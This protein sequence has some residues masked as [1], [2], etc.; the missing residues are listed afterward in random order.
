[1]EIK[2]SENSNKPIYR[3]IMDAIVAAIDKNEL[4]YGSKLPTE[5]EMAA[6]LGVSRGTVKK[7]FAELE[8]N[9]I[10]SLVWGSGAYVVY[11]T[12]QDYS[13]LDKQVGSLLTQ[14]EEKDYSSAEAENYL[15]IKRRRVYGQGKVFFAVV[16]ETPE[17]LESYSRQLAGI[18][19]LETETFL[20]EELKKYDNRSAI[21]REFDGILTVDACFEQMMGLSPELRDKIIKVNTSPDKET[22]INLI[23]IVEPQ[24]LGIL[25]KSREFRDVVN[26]V[27]SLRGIRIVDKDTLFERWAGIEEFDKFIADKKHLIVPPF[28]SLNLRPEIYEKIFDF[29]RDGGNVIMFNYTIEKSFYVYIE[30]KVAKMLY[31]L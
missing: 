5:R 14:M 23:K 27:L 26:D 11:R 13:E 30:E 7:V 29:I 1:M 2:L 25:V 15:N 21:L 22:G 9:G 18:R 17:T 10:I 24:K 6:S 31:G 3:Q 8:K 19:G 16:G 20:F 28:Y 4:K 12:E